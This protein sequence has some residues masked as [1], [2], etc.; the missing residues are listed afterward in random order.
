MEKSEILFFNQVFKFA[1]KV[2]RKSAG[3]NTDKIIL[4]S[5]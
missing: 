2:C 5:N 3:D 4:Q 1:K